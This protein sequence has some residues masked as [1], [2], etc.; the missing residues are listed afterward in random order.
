[1][2]RFVFHY[3]PKSAWGKRIHFL[4]HGVHHDYPNDSKRLVLPPAMSTILSL[5]FLC[6][7]YLTLGK[8]YLLFFVG[9]MLG[10]LTYDTLHYA[11][12]HSS[13]TNEYFKKMKEQHMLHHYN[14]NN[15][16]YGVTSE[17]WDKV[18]GTRLK[19]G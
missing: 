6:L 13:F 3:E 1:M 14:D 17:F 2:H 11:L 4:A 9:F 16:G 8:Y 15:S 10:Y 5:P 12:H 19:K 18:F 7:F